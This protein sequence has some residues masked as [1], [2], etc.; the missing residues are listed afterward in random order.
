MSDNESQLGA[1]SDNESQLGAMSDSK[2]QLGAMSDSES[3][4]EEANK[5]TYG[6]VCNDLGCAYVVRKSVKTINEAFKLLIE[7][8]KGLGEPDYRTD[9]CVQFDRGQHGETLVIIKNPDKLMEELDACGCRDPK[10][11]SDKQIIWYSL[12]DEGDRILDRYT[13]EFGNM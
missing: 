10:M 8:Y 5:T 9:Y 3:P 12:D 13:A 11:P 7:S 2:S 1:M 4:P 6:V